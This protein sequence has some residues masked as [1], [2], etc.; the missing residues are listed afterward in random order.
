MQNSFAFTI[1]TLT[2]SLFLFAC[3]ALLAAGT[4]SARAQSE[5]GLKAAFLFNFA[6]FT[7]WPGSAFP[8]ASAKIVVGFVGA[9]GLADTFEKNVSGKNANGR[10]FTVKKLADAAGAA[11][12]HIVVA[13]KGDAVVAAAKG[14][15]VLTVGDGEAFAKGGGGIGFVTDGPKVSFVLNL[16]GV[17]GAG[18]KMDPKLQKFAKS[19]IE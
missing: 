17:K 1:S 18:L 16:G 7:E 6:K 10:E 9:D 19:T 2:R 5:E 15:P 3:A 11:E 8:D 4:F 14:K 13:G 12:C